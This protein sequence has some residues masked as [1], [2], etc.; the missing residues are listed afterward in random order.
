MAGIASTKKTP[1]GKFTVT[2]L[3]D[4]D[5][6]TILSTDLNGVKNCLRA[7]LQNMK[8]GG[9]IINCSSTAGQYGPPNSGPYAA[10]KWGVIGLTKSVAKEVGKQGI[11]VNALAPYVSTLTLGIAY[12][13]CFMR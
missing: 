8:G 13:E 12:S 11:R 4:D 10:S 1:P 5:W 6:D 9:S 3:E 2:I 7:E